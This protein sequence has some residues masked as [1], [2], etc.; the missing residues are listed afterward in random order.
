MPNPGGTND[1]GPAGSSNNLAALFPVPNSVAKWT[2]LPGVP[3]ALPLSDETLKPFNLMS[4]TTHEYVAAPDGKQALAATYP[5]GSYIPSKDP[6]GGFSFY[7]LGP[8]TVDFTAAREL[9][10]GYSVMFPAGFQWQK[11]GKLPGICEF[12]A[13]P[14]LCVF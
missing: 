14:S 7:A 8:D 6:R 12:R 9:T 13:G 3:D 2:T 4:G 5:K 10:L 11:G 1:T